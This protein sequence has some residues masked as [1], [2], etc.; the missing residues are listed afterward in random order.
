MLY[1]Q[2]R[3]QVIYTIQV[4]LTLAETSPAIIKSLKFNMYTFLKIEVYTYL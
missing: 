1:V 3:L 4:M 2:S